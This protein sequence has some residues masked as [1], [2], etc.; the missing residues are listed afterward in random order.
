MLLIKVK[1]SLNLTPFD[2]LKKSVLSYR[3][4]LAELYQY[5]LPLLT[6]QS[7]VKV[8]QLLGKIFCNLSV[9]GSQRRIVG[10]SKTLHFLLPDLVMPID[11][12]FTMTYCYGYNRYSDKPE[13]EFKDFKHIFDRTIKITKKLNLTS[14]DVKGGREPVI[15]LTHV[16]TLFILNSSQYS[17][18]GQC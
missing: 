9:M 18:G 4:E 7:K 13:K 15:L 11:S 8:E 3:Q 10:V 16:S 17:G 12:K 5:Q 14:E 6:D 1:P 2:T